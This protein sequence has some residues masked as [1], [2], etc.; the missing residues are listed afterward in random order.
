MGFGEAVLRVIGAI[1][2]LA[3]VLF[4]AWLMLRWMNGRMPG[5][6]GGSG[7][8]IQVLDRL[9][10]GR[11]SGLLLVRVHNKVLLV[12]FSDQHSQTLCEFDDPEGSIKA[13]DDVEPISFQDALKNAARQAGF[14]KG[15]DKGEDK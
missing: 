13:L 11:G 1:V 3:L 6:R 15:K 7:R 2:A 10:F 14:G 4:L 9:S 5:N 12:G 8:M